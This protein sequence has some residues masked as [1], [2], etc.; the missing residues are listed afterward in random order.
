[1]ILKKKAA[2]MQKLTTYQ[3]LTQKKKFYIVEVSL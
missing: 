1:M 2:P 3:E